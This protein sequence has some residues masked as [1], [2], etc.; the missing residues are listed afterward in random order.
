MSLLDGLDFH[1]TENV[2]SMFDYKEVHPMHTQLLYDLEEVSQL[3]NLPAVIDAFRAL[4]LTYARPS[5]LSCPGSALTLAV[6]LK[7][8]TIIRYLLSEGVLVSPN[9]VRIAT[10]KK[11]KTLIQLFLN[12]GWPINQRL[13]WSDPL[14]LA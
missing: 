13:G 9:H 11:S 2:S 7:H 8:E 10:S 14:A 1:A 5:V 4:R 6:E 12:C 3:D